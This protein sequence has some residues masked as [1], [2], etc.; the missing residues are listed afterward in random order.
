MHHMP[1]PVFI[2]SMLVHATIEAS[3]KLFKPVVALGSWTNYQVS[4]KKCA[5]SLLQQ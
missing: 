4:Q 2:S 1:F 3:F 5:S